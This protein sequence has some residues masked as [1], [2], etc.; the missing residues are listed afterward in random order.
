MADDTRQPPPSADTP[1]NRETLTVSPENK[2]F[3]GTQWQGGKQLPASTLPPQNANILGGGTEHTAGGKEPDVTFRNAFNKG[4]PTWEDFKELPKRPCV[5]DAFMTG[6]GG[7]FA[8]GGVRAIFE[9]RFYAWF[10]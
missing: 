5:R 8:M 2:P 1:I 7:G 4:I 6:I 9:V 10:E 3:S